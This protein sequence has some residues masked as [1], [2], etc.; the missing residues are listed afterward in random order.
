MPS[1]TV[2]KGSKGGHVQKSQTSK[3]DLQNDQVLV[4]VT[5]SGLCGT[6]LHYREADMVLGHE[7]V[8]VVEEVGPAVTHLKKGERVGWGYEHDRYV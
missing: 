6:D 2:F 3:P 8:G 1:F 5:A 4:R 7:G